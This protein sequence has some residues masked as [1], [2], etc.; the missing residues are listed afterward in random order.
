MQTQNWSRT[1]HGEMETITIHLKE[2]RVKRGRNLVV[3][4]AI[5]SAMSDRYGQMLTS[6]PMIRDIQDAINLGR[7]TSQVYG[8]WRRD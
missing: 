2:T 6:S 5:Q 3:I 4:Q 8:F 7:K 1:T